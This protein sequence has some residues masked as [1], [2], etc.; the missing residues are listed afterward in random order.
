[1]LPSQFPDWKKIGWH[2]GK[3]LKDILSPSP[4]EAGPSKA[5]RKAQRLRDIPRGFAYLDDFDELNSWVTS[6]VDPVQQAN[7]P[8]LARSTDSIQDSSSEKSKVLLCH[9]YNGGYHDYEAVRPDKMSSELYSCH[10]LQYVDTFVYFSHKL[11]CVPPPTWT[12]TLHRNGVKVLGTCIVEPQTPDIEKMLVTANG[13]FHIAEQL[14]RMADAYGFDGWLLN[15]EKEFSTNVTKQLLDF[16]KCLK[17]ALGD[18]RQVIWYDALDTDNYVDHQNEL[19]MKNIEFARAAGA[20]FTNYK[21][22]EVNLQSSETLARKYDMDMREIYF[23]IDVWAQNTNMPGPPRVTFPS[24]GGGGT[25]TGFVCF[26]SD[27]F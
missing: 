5:E 12:N 2:F 19:T 25:N 22:T 1:M 11:V 26:S 4:G 13:S 17:Q 15:I 23:G 16:I 9:D 10:Y 6:D 3:K 8:L 20:L 27:L 21:W 7:T 24:E 14:A 18:C